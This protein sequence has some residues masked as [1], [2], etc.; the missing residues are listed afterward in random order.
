M[1]EP[2]TKRWTVA[3]V[4]AL[5]YDE[6]NRYEIIDGELFVSRQPRD[7]HQ[8][9]S[10]E[11]IIGL[12]NWNH[13]TRLGSVLHT[14]G[15]IFSNHDAVAPD[16]V[17]IS[18]ERRAAVE[19]QDDGHLHGAPELVVEILSP[20]AANERRDREIK[21]QLYSDQGVDEYWIVDQR[22]QTV[23]VYRRHDTRLRLVETLQ[24]DD[25]LTSP[26]LPGFSLP[27]AHIFER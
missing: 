23:A 18:R 14:P 1:A 15:L 19:R 21:L 13:Q 5:P 8:D 25:A 24:R 22:A 26:L 20:G 12:G 7:E 4:E 27:V 3:D 16:I 17:W 11:I 2:Q 9:A 10:G 6:W